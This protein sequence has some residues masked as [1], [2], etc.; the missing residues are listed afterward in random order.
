MAIGDF[1][2]WCGKWV[3]NHKDG[4]AC[5]PPYPHPIDGKCIGVATA[6]DPAA[7]I[8]KT[9]TELRYHPDGTLDEV[10][11]YLGEQCVFHMEQMDGTH[12]WMACYTDDVEEL[13]INLY[14]R[15]RIRA[16]VLETRKAEEDEDGE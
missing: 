10:V 12:W 1:M 8:A 5:P 4:Q 7:R 11:I 6:P 9:R 15:G 2:C 16:D 3:A 14:A 13:H